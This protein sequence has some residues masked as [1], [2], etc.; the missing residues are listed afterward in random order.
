MFH[1]V[2]NGLFR[3]IP[4]MIMDNNAVVA[5]IG[6]GPLG[7]EM[8]I[9]LKSAQ[10][11]CMIFDKGQI[12]QMIYNFPP[13]THFF[14]SSDKIAIAGIPLQTEDQQKCTRE[15]YLSYLRTVVGHYQLKVNTFEEVLEVRR[16]NETHFQLKTQS[17]K[18]IKHYQVNYII[19]ATGSTSH[20]RLLNIPGESASHVS[21]K[22]SDPHQYFKKKVVIIGGKNSAAESALRCFYAGASVSIILRK[23]AF[24]PQSVKYWIL[25]D[26]LSRIE[27]GDIH[28]YYQSEVQEI[29]PDAVKIQQ[30]G[31]QETKNVPADFVIK[32]IGFDAD[33]KLCEQLGVEILP[34]LHTP[35]YNSK[36]METNV[37][38]IYVLGTIIGGTQQRYIIFIENTHHHIEKILES[39]QDK[40]GIFE[41]SNKGL[42]WLVATSDSS[43]QL[44]Q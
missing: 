35:T 12:G 21:T 24:E 38:G 2:I 34:P 31:T 32:A 20:P 42:D 7:L 19:L 15:T 22:M 33:M 37:E 39:L 4:K 17:N 44:E 36:T 14:S 1:L 9:A 26:L 3:T 23:E 41:D 25:P 40:L 16:L 6:A 8:A 28:C 11:S 18:G 30:R 13:E 43:H 27:K 29:Y 5:I 10:I